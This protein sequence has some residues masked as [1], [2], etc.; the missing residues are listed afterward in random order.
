M[1]HFMFGNE[2][3]NYLK[4]PNETNFKMDDNYDYMNDEILSICEMWC[5]Y[6]G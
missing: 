5:Y 4:R 1:N 2:I 3:L 6:G